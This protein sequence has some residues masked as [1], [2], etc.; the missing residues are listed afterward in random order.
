MHTYTFPLSPRWLRHFS[1]H[2]HRL[3]TLKHT[4]QTCTG[5]P[6]TAYSASASLLPQPHILMHSGTLTCTGSPQS[7]RPGAPGRRGSAPPAAAP[8]AAPPRQAARSTP[9]QGPGGRCGK[10]WWQPGSPT[11]RDSCRLHGNITALI[12]L[13]IDLVVFLLPVAR[14]GDSTIYR[15]HVYGATDRHVAAPMA[16]SDAHRSQCR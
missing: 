12:I 3:R 15:Q 16:H 6:T 7:S 10:R 2:R 4:T 9:R 14:R 11:H 8:S 5:A 1:A 13:I